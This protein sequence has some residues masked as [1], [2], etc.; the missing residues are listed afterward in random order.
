VSEES[1]RVSSGPEGN[2]A[3]ID[4]TAVALALA[5]AG[6]E[7][8]NA[9]L[10]R[11]GALAEDQRALISDQRHH[12]HEQLNQIHLDVWEKRLGVLLRIATAFIGVAIA[13]ALTYVIADAASSNDLVIESFAVPPDLA[14][15]GLSGPVVAAKLSDKIATL[16]AETVSQR[17]PRSYANGLT[18]GL[19][20]EIPET[21]VSLF[22]LDRFLR[23]KL[24]HD[25]HIGGE[26]VQTDMGV[27]LTARVG[28]NGSA[29]VA[30]AE[31]AVDMLLQKLAEQVYR[32]TQPYRYGIWLRTHGRIEESID[33]LK[34]L[35]TSG[36]SGER[37][38]AYDGWANDIASIQSERAGQALLRRG[39]AIDPYNYL[40]ATNIASSEDRFGRIQDSQRDFGAALAILLAHGREYSLPVRLR[41]VEHSIRAVMFMDQGALLEALDLQRTYVAEGNAL[42]AFFVSYPARLPE[43]L[44]ALHEPG[45][46]RAALAEIPVAITNTS[47]A[48]LS[49][50]L[51]LRARLTVALEAQDWP[52]ALAVDQE[53]PQVVAQYPGF[54][55]SRVT[56]VDPVAALSLAQIGK[57][58]MA[59]ARLRPMPEDCYP[60]LRARAQVAALEKQDSRADYWFARAVAADPSLPYA[61]SEWGRTR[62]NRGQADA[63]IE[64]FTVSN[65]KGPHFADPL[66][67]WGEA[68]M[69]KNQSHLA[70]TK[71]AEAEKYAPNWG[72]LHLKWG[73][74]LAYVGKMDE[75]KTHFTR[76]A[77]LDLTPS[78]K[79]ELARHP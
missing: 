19:K 45:A 61:E 60:C 41:G 24:G 20:L 40:L 59:E 53:L 37:G 62:L 33:V 66:E 58:A 14:A 18:A 4:P 1:E 79:A 63:A 12:L 47:N 23:E 52:E 77:V 69:A 46:A 13:A 22:E 7:E 3:G 30:G 78:E 65:R 76:A 54:A 29:T 34:N 72:R 32:V 39:H 35:A 51:A 2:G 21:G 42:G 10:K 38:W 74:A 36:P 31:T 44:A 17:P 56:F 49:L 70:L 5:G 75:A 43:I 71:F 68:L 26:M 11:Q 28:T 67:G 50:I 8:A 57:F 73:E 55:E 15:R 9:F 64:M 6:R 48:G 16:Q 27:A 25:V